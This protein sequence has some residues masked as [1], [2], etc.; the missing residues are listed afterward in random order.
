MQSARRL[1]AGTGMGLMLGLPLLAQP[2]TAGAESQP[3]LQ[4]HR[5][6]VSIAMVPDNAP[7]PRD[8]GSYEPVIVG[9]T[10]GPALDDP[11]LFPGPALGAS[12]DP[13]GNGG[14]A[15]NRIVS[16]DGSPA[17]SPIATVPPDNGLIGLFA[18]ISIICIIGVSV[19]AVRAVV[20]QRAIRAEFA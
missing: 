19:G 20:S 4:F 10:S 17:M 15:V 6:P 16:P 14:E 11:L 13:S 2:A 7:D 8:D 18:T 1:A 9:V 3:Q 12:L 5:G